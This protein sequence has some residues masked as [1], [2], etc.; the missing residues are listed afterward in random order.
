M[1]PD[2]M[3]PSIA[4]QLPYI[5]LTEN[6][7]IDRNLLKEHLV[8]SNQIHEI[9]LPRNSVEVDISRIWGN[10][11]DKRKIGVQDNFFYLGG[12]S[13]LANQV[14]LR[15]ESHFNVKLE[16]RHLFLYPTIEKLALF[17]PNAVKYEY[18]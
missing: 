3:I 9:I 7:K 4:Y 5:P 13:L 10:V 12:D 8:K 15:L 6:G 14:I 1:L 18:P 16:L 17:I 2:I 11:L